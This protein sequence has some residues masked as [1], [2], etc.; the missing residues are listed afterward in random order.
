MLRF[1]IIVKKQVILSRFSL[2]TP[3]N[4]QFG[5]LWSVR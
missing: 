1:N 2:C 5:N 3:W 4:I